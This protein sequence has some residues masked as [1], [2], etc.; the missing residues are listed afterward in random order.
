MEL[1]LIKLK[2][3][4]NKLEKIITNRKELLYNPST[5]IIDTTS[6]CNNNCFFCWRRDNLDHLKTIP[7]NFH[8]MPFELLKKIIDDITQYKSI[9]TLSFSGPMGEPMMNKNIEKFCQYA[10]SKKHF[11]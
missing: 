11:K 9:N 1:F 10:H 6:L 7:A 2:H 3:F 8:T 5:I 4:L